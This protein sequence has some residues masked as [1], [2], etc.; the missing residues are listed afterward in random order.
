M[1]IVQR[2]KNTSIPF[3]QIR[4]FLSIHHVSL[5]LSILVGTLS[6]IRNTLFHNYCSVVNLS[7]FDA[8]LLCNLSFL[9]YLYLLTQ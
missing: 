5:P 8:M 1:K 4:T 9:I 7:N 6:K 2:T 3:I